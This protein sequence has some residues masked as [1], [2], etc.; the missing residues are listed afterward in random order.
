MN[1]IRII[2]NNLIKLFIPRHNILRP[3]IDATKTIPEDF[4]SFKTGDPFDEN[5]ID[6]LPREM[7][8]EP[9]YSTMLSEDLVETPLSLRD[10]SPKVQEPLEQLQLVDKAM[11]ISIRR[12]NEDTVL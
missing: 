12:L 11:G 7:I 10:Q 5:D 8:P 6:E 4:E 3:I 9:F 2:Y 1:F